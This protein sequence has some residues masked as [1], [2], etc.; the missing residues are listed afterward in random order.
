MSTDP[1]GDWPS[2]PH[3]VHHERRRSGLLGMAPQ[4]PPGEEV[5]ALCKYRSGHRRPR[6]QQPARRAGSSTNPALLFLDR[7]LSRRAPD[8]VLSTPTLTSSRRPNFLPPCC[9]PPPLQASS[10][11]KRS[12]VFQIKAG[13]I[14]WLLLI[15]SSKGGVKRGESVFYYLYQI[16]MELLNPAHREAAEVVVL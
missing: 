7:F 3:G 15:P 6:L 16:L 14:L 13:C 2:S 10:P 11:V 12:L 4:V 1:F 5:E 8:R 9:R